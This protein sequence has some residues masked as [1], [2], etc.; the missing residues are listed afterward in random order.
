[1]SRH[2]TVT[3]VHTDLKEDGIWIIFAHLVK[4]GLND[5]AR[6]TPGGGVVYDNK[7]VTGTG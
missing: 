1:M 3:H 7:A 4:H 2:N 5:L 6:P